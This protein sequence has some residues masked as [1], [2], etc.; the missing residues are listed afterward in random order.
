MLNVVFHNLERSELVKSAAVERFWQLEERFPRLQNCKITLTFEM[1]NSP[2][3][4]GADLFSVTFYCNDGYF[5]GLKMKKH[6]DDLYAALWDLT[7]TLQL[8]LHKF[9]RKSRSRKIHQVRRFLQKQQE[10]FSA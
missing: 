5:A 9:R 6:S 1:E 8:K 3:K 10:Q 4:P 2:T 7:D